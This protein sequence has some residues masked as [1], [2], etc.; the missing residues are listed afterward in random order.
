MTKWKVGQK[1]YRVIADD[2]GTVETWEYEV[3]TIRAG[4]VHATLR[5]LHVTVDSKGRWLKRIPAWCRYTWRVEPKPDIFAPGRFIGEKPADLCTTKLAAARAALKS[6]RVGDF[7][8]EACGERAGRTLKRM[9][10]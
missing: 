9:A 6:H 4:K 10:A 5:C 2:E 8:D 7:E 3:R 1:L